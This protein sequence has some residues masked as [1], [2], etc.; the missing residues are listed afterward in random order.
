MKLRI[1]LILIILIAK[2]GKA[3]TN[4]FPTSGNVGIGTTTPMEKLQVVGGL[5]V[6]KNLPYSDIRLFTD[7]AL[8]GYNQTNAIIPETIPGSGIA[9]TALHLKNAVSSGTNRMDLI[10]DGFV[11]IGTTNPTEKLSVNGKIRA[12]EIKVETAN[13]PDYVF[14]DDYKLSSLSE[15]EKYIKANKHLPEMPSAKEVAANGIE[16]GEMN[17]LLLKKVEELTLHLIQLNNKVEKLE[18]QVKNN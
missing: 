8:A 9:K 16:L 3:Q 10:V 2:I 18:K 14:E 11:G 4:T 5:R 6:G 12:H 17:K 13:W 7:N 15:I 1:L